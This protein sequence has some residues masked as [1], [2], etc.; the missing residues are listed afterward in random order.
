[1]TLFN[2]Q[3]GVSLCK[4]LRI[5]PEPPSWFQLE[6]G[7]SRSLGWGSWLPPRGAVKLCKI[8]P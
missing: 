6:E 8:L 2:V 7:P 3:G 4:H 1:M 5:F